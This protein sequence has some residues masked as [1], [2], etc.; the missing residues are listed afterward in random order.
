MN[1]LNGFQGETEARRHAGQVLQPTRFGEAINQYLAA[2]GYPDPY[3]TVGQHAG[4][5]PADTGQQT[6]GL[7][8]VG[9]DDSA[10]SCI[11]VD[12]AAIEAALHS[13]ALRLVNVRRSASDEAGVAL[14]RRLLA[15]VQASAP[16]VAAVARI[17]V[18]SDTSEALL[19]EAGDAD[20]VV[21]GHHQGA[22]ASVVG[23]S[24]AGRVARN[25]TRPLLIVRMPGWPA[26]FGARPLMVAVDGSPASR[27]SVQFAL[28]EA[29]VRGC[30]VT[31][32][33][34]IGSGTD[35]ARRHEILG[36]V[37]VRHRILG[38]DPVNALVEASDAAAAMVIAQHGLS[39]PLLEMAAR[40]LP[41]K[42]L[43]PVFLV[44]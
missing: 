15:R 3:A 17:A 10:I 41:Q 42:A 26:E 35:L 5:A 32:L 22:A 28:D 9:V 13:W 44:G 18:G 23:L 37:T 1:N 11:A 36:G 19:A 14:L 40:V 7:V 43:C 4:T 20:L 24:V 16:E 8:V 31:L 12:H 21:V 33:H 25:H 27:K 2:T 39:A 6:S 38:G 34:L 29:R 30:D